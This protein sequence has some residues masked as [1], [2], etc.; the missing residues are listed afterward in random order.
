MLW[1]LEHSQ[2]FGLITKW[3]ES[4]GPACPVENRD[5]AEGL[6]SSVCWPRFHIQFFSKFIKVH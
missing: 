5:G 2:T 6:I 3:I 1:Y 4:R